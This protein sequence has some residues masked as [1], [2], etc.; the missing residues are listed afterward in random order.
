MKKAKRWSD[1]IEHT[2]KKQKK[3]RGDK[4]WQREITTAI[5]AKVAALIHK[6]LHQ[7]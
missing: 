3:N 5:V 4:E 1:T 7:M 6:D 2:N